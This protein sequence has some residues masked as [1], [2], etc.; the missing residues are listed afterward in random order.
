MKLKFKLGEETLVVASDKLQYTVGVEK[1]INKNGTPTL[2]LDPEGYYTTFHGLL[3]AL[4]ERGLRQSTATEL[5]ELVADV[6]TLRQD[7]G[8]LVKR[9]RK[10]TE[11]NRK[12][13]RR[14]RT[15]RASR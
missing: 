9:L 4:L 2:H 3:S 8:L 7:L 12:R 6:D 10:P 14:K 15:R 1:T 5:R 11:P 13:T